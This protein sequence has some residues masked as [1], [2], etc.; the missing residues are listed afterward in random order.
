MALN[1]FRPFSHKGLV[2]ESDHCENIKK[3]TLLRKEKLTVIIKQRKTSWF[4][5]GFFLVEG[6]GLLSLLQENAVHNWYT[7]AHGV[8]IFLTTSWLPSKDTTLETT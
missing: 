4:F 2:I 1:N 7:I 6:L 5:L 8:P 3:K